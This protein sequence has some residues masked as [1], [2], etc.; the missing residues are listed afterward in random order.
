MVSDIANE[1]SLM[2][3]ANLSAKDLKAVRLVCHSWSVLAVSDLF[4]TVYLSSRS[5]DLEVFKHVASH[6]LIRNAVRKMVY[7]SSV[8]RE[9]SFW[10]Y[11][12]QL[13]E[14]FREFTLDDLNILCPDALECFH[15]VPRPCSPRIDL[16]RYDFVR[17][18]HKEYERYADEEF[19]I[20]LSGEYLCKIISGLKKLL[21]LELVTVSDTCQFSSPFG[22]SWPRE[23]LTPQAKIKKDSLYRT[24]IY[25]HDHSLLVRA[26]SISGIKLKSLVMN[27]GTQD[28]VPIESFAGEVLL[29]G[30]NCSI[31]LPIL[32]RHIKNAYCD[33][34]VLHLVSSVRI[35]SDEHLLCLR[36][37]LAEIHG[38]T[39]LHLEF[40][41]YYPG[42]SSFGAIL[43]TTWPHLI[44][45]SISFMSVKGED[46]IHFLSPKHSLNPSL[47]SFTMGNIM[48]MDIRWFEVLDGICACMSKAKD[49]FISGPLI[50][51]EGSESWEI[52]E[53][54]NKD[55]KKQIENYLKL[56]GVN[57]L[58]TPE[59]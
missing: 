25:Q 45:V 20:R 8:L 49:I 42:S 3:F 35:S 40:T 32:N 30:E 10:Q 18:G 2:I 5:K 38:L 31:S 37:C 29:D 24:S 46:L 4:T 1:I 11:C 23:Y 27:R 34:K 26:L 43:G 6:E 58:I 21:N 47:Q 28:G 57:P 19:D 44:H 52:L 17:L 12:I 59:Q 22:R 13:S 33:L 51:H 54:G 36:S 53:R 9:F 50:H 39:N 7:D 55:L 48:L 56:G 14:Q 16:E 15:L 41:E